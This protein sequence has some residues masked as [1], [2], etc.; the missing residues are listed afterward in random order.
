MRDFSDFS[1]NWLLEINGVPCNI[2]LG[3]NATGYG[4]TE[5][6]APDGYQ[7][8]VYFQCY[9]DDRMDLIA[10]LVGTVKYQ[11][12]TI[13]RTDPFAYP[14][15]NQDS[16]DEDG[17]VYPNRL[18]CTS[19]SSIAGTKPWT[20]ASGDNVGLANWLGY[21][22][23]V[24]QAEFTSPPY[25]IEDLLGDG[26]T[27]TDPSFNDLSYQ[28]YCTSNIRASGEVFS[29]PGGAFI[30]ATG[31]LAGKPLQDLGASQI[32]T[33]S[34]ITITRIR[35][36]LIPMTTIGSLIGTVNQTPFLIAGQLFPMGSMLFNGINPSPR[37][38]PYNRGIIWD[39]ELTFLG[40]SPANTNG[41]VL[42]WNYFLD[43]MGVWS[44]VTT[45]GGA[46]AFAYADHTQLYQDAIT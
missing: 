30:W 21:A 10:G 4:I 26:V 41:I 24:I 14:L 15:S 40:N 37:S 19:I 1:K 22:Y 11:G 8:T 23:A 7:A 17:N 3:D 16:I 29:P 12:N 25:L 43:P 31:A 46:P 44:L 42:D 34:E 28:T 32:R 20:D 36:P 18:F 45:K 5:S 2:Y 35:M 33:R 38:D 9:W 13:I 6:N 39:I 27:P